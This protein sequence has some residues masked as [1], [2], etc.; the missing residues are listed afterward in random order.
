M[1]CLYTCR[2]S[3]QYLRYFGHESAKDLRILWCKNCTL[4]PCLPE[5]KEVPEG[6]IHPDVQKPC[7]HHVWAWWSQV[8]GQG[9]HNVKSCTNPLWNIPA[10]FQANLIL[11]LWLFQIRFKLEKNRWAQR[12]VSIIFTRKFLTTRNGLKSQVQFINTMQGYLCPC[13]CF[14][15]CPPP[16]YPVWNH[17]HIMICSAFYIDQQVKVS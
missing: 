9:T 13:G 6:A 15:I 16:Y 10:C 12:N 7:S 1:P 8:R 14:C 17:P 5:R 2:Q 4:I 3:K 11:S